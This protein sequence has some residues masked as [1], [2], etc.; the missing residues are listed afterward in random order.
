MVYGE[1]FG[2]A[3]PP[4]QLFLM[5]YDVQKLA[6]TKGYTLLMAVGPGRSMA[7]RLSRHHR[8]KSR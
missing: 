1:R 4:N 3:I 2:G 7:F 8:P 6:Q 5:M